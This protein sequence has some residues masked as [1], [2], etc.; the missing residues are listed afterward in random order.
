MDNLLFCPIRVQLI[1]GVSAF[2]AIVATMVILSVPNL[3]GQ[4][5]TFHTRYPSSTQ[6]SLTLV[7]LDNE[8]NQTLQ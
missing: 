8:T 7:L 2:E 5:K 1:G 6:K 3:D 4:T